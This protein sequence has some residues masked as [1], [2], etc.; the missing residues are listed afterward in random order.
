MAATP[1]PGSTVTVTATEYKLGLDKLSGLPPPR[2]VVFSADA[3]PATG[4][5]WCPDCVKAL[6]VIQQLVHEAQ[7]SLLEVQV[8]PRPVWK[9]PD[10]PFRLDPQL[11]LTGIPTLATW[12]PDGLG[13]RV[14]PELEAANDADEVSDIVK[15]LISEA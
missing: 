1:A 7:G 6:P 10:H 4:L 11:K 3:D 5:P 8:G 15:K 9:S 12:T 2:F 13:G 14:G